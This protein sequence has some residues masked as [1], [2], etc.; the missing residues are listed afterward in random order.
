MRFDAGAPPRHDRA[1]SA[2]IRGTLVLDFTRFLTHLG[3]DPAKVF[4]AAGYPLESALDRDTRVP[5][6]V[7][8]ALLETAARMLDMPDFGLRLAEFRQMPDLGPV[9]LFLREKETL[10]DVLET[11]AQAFHLH[12]N[13]LYLTNIDMGDTIVHAIELLTTDHRLSRQSAEMIVAGV[14]EMFRWILGPDWRPAGILFRHARVL[15]ERTY[16]AHFGQ[17]PEFEQEY[18]AIV[19]ERA[20]LSL[21]LKRA[22]PAFDK[23]ARAILADVQSAPE[24]FL[25]RVRQLIVLTL[26]QG[27]ARADRIAGLLGIDRRTLHRRLSRE[28]LT[29]SGLLHDVRREFAQQYVVSTDRSMAEIA[30]LVGFESPAVFSRWYRDAMG[31]TPRDSRAAARAGT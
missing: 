17:V 19:L 27:E 22:A 26:G 21:S 24:V 1:M 28:G 6:E 12:S 3:Q 29:F 15:P 23:D 16:L 7:P 18:N 14:R 9:A 4:S 10:G 8:T 5:V 25:Y 31:Q 20:D 2:N 30:L 11:I 13:A